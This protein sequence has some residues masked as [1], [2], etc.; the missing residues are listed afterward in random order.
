MCNRYAMQAG[1]EML[2][3]YFKAWIDYLGNLPPM[4]GIFTDY[5][6]PIVRNGA[7]GRELALARWGL[8]SPAYAL[9]G[10]KTDPGV[11]NVRNVKSPHWRRWL[12]VENRCV[13]PFTS[14]SE[15][16]VLADGSRPPVWLPSMKPG[17]CHASPGYGYRN[18]NQCG[19]SRKRNKQRPVRVPDDRIEQGSRSNSPK[20]H[21]GHSDNAG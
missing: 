14:F 4:P 10:K 13:V 16:E 20:G 8:P 17:R 11:T 7:D 3:E 12:G 21:A 6:A 19:S 15:N 9:K 1:Q 18:G 2:R 5:A